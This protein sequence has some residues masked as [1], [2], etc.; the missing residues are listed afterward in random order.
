MAAAFLFGISSS[1]A[2]QNEGPA[3]CVVAGCGG[4][5][6]GGAAAAAAGWLFMAVRGE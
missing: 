4:G 5:G 2:Y 1:T 3:P 6:G